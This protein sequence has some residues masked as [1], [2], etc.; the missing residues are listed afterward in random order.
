MKKRNPWQLLAKC[1]GLGIRVGSKESP[2]LHYR[3]IIYVYM[4]CVYEIIGSMDMF[5]FF[6]LETL[7]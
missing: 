2:V 5:Y 1:L 6:D 3:V 4:P 7:T